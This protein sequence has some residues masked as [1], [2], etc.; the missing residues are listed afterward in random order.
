MT[1]AFNLSQ[2]ANNLNS[3]GQLDATDGLVNA[4]P[5]ANGG[6]GA[7]TAAAARTNLNVPTR[8][9]GDASGTW[10]INIT[11]NAATAT[12]ATSATNATNATNATFATTAGNG[13]VT[14]VNGL[15]GAVTVSVVPSSFGAVGSVVQALN[16]S[17]SNLLP[18]NTIAGSSLLYVNGGTFLTDTSAVI[19]L[20]G[21]D[22]IYQ[23]FNPSISGNFAGN[24]GAAQPP[25]TAT[26]SGT[27]RVLSPATVRFSLYDALN[28]TTYVYYVGVLVQR[29]S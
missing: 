8:T 10:A 26:L 23:I 9:G 20:G 7:S 12:S 19:N 13:G 21:V 3:A 14:S 2:L 6:T 18:G 1:Q 5:V 22:I 29:I 24:V 17:T 27:W 28:A 16:W 25:N 4:V 11:G 15:T